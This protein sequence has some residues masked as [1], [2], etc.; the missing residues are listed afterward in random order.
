MTGTEAYIVA[1]TPTPVGRRNGGLATAHP[2]DLA[3]HV[4]VGVLSRAAVDADAVDDVIIGCVDQAGAQ[5]SNIARVAVLSAGL[6]HAVPA[7]TIDRQCGSSQQAVH[8]A[9]QAIMSGSQDIVV[10][11][12]WLLDHGDGWGQPAAPVTSAVLGH[13][14]HG[15]PAGDLT[16]DDL[17]DNI[18]LYWLTNTAVSAARLYWK[19][20]PV[21]TTPPTS[22]SRPP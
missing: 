6:P 8:F 18:T 10:A 21:C 9:A 19:T 20:R 11:A 7:T 17:L 12:A 16:R 2:A 4:L 3:A 22:G 15:H 1:A 13:T 5:A 14:S